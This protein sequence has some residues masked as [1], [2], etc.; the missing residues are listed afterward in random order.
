MKYIVSVQNSIHVVSGNTL[1]IRL[2][3]LPY[4]RLNSLKVIN[5]SMQMGTDHWGPSIMMRIQ[6][7]V[8]NA[9]DV[10]G[11][12]ATVAM[13]HP[14]AVTA[15]Y[16]YLS[17][18]VNPLILLTGPLTELVFAFS[19]ADGTVVP[20]EDYRENVGLY[21]GSVALLVVQNQAVTDAD[22]ALR[23]PAGNI[24]LIDAVEAA[25]TA[26]AADPDNAGLIA[27]ADA[28]QAALDAPLGNTELLANI[29]A[30]QAALDNDPGNAGL[31]AAR[32][33]AI[34][35]FNAVA[36]NAA[37][38]DTYNAAQAALAAKQ[39][40]QDAVT[41]AYNALRDAPGNVDEVDLY[42]STEAALTLDPGNPALIAQRDDALA[43][44]LA[45]AGNDVLLDA[46]NNAI[47]AFAVGA[48]LAELQI[49]A[50][51]ADT[52]LNAPLGN[53]ELQE[54]LDAAI[55]ARDATITQRDAYAADVATSF[56]S[57]TFLLE[58][59]IE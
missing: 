28:A 44:L 25:E 42:V 34:A 58:L 7:S 35:A 23:A 31:I 41:A 52:A 54:D 1:R 46:Y 37:L 47:A 6:R 36:G 45:I 16:M 56:V 12:Y 57:T 17:S 40:L 14:T 21:E 39:A 29:T 11:G 49:A 50:V 5:V 19:R 59:D 22:A 10:L 13:A 48:T 9:Y 32:D 38:L 18:D 27:A 53:I 51:A 24:A 43:A 33:A 55:A 4:G 15:Q 3:A 8:M 30:A 26:L 20:I 2:D